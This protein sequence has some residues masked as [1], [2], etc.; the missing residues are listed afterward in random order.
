M[1]KM[2]N[3]IEYT[4]VITEHL[5]FLKEGNNVDSCDYSK[6]KYPRQY[7][8]MDLRRKADIGSPDI[9]TPSYKVSE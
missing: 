9:G 3:G 4:D 7:G 1:A 6:E 8:K 5:P 2:K